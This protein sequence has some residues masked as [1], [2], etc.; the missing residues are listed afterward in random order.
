MA[1]RS[2]PGSSWRRSRRT[3]RRASAVLEAARATACASLG[4]L[5]ALASTPAAALG[6]ALATGGVDEAPSGD[7]GDIDDADAEAEAGPGQGDEEARK[8]EALAA[9]QEARR[10]YLEGDYAA[11][12]AEFRRSFDTLPSLEALVASARAYAKGGQRIAAVDVYEEYMEFEDE[13]AERHAEAQRHLRELRGQIGE[14]VVRLEAPESA[15]EIR[16]NGEVVALSDFPKWIV[17]GPIR[18]EIVERGSAEPR[19]ITA[20]VRGGEKAVIDVPRAR[21][22]PEPVVAEPEPAPIVVEPEPEPEPRGLRRAFWAG[23]GLTGAAALATAT[24]GGLTLR[25]RQMYADALCAVDDSG[26]CV[27]GSFYPHDEEARFFELRRAT[28]VLVGVTAG[29]AVVTLALGVAA[30]R[31]SQR[32]QRSQGRARVR[33]DLDAG[34]VAVRF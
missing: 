22:E 14:I 30:R 16:L 24:L 33:L 5:V 31:A 1:L 6:P 2:A 34:G 18:L 19:V 28:N 4:V 3:S 32:S 7:I 8:A 15:E 17:P 20:L 27:D 21:P 23:V 13:D 10:L 29:V 9:F 26:G 12:A 25:Q 11:A